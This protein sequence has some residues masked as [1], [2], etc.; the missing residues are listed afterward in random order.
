VIWLLALQLSLSPQQQHND[1]PAAG[2]SLL[3]SNSDVMG[4]SEMRCGFFPKEEATTV[5]AK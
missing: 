4:Q 5:S 2:R 3:V 1:L